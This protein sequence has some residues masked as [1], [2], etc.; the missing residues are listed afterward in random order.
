LSLLDLEALCRIQSGEL[1]NPKNW[2]PRPV[3][4]AH[5]V[6]A[7]VK[8]FNYTTDWVQTEILK[9]DDPKGRCKVMKHYVAICKELFALNNF[10]AVLAIVCAF[11]S[12]AIGRLHATLDLFHKRFLTKKEKAFLQE[13]ETLADSSG[14]W[15]K[16]RTTMEAAVPPGVP[17]IG[18]FLSDLLWIDEG[19]PETLPNGLINFAKKRLIGVIIQRLRAFQQRR[20]AFE[21]VEPIR[22]WLDNAEV[23]DNDSLFDLSRKLEPPA[24]LNVATPLQPPPS[25]SP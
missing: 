21:V 10:H 14:N 13:A 16:M 23:R 18:I 25:Q 12:P 6:L 20:Y 24:V 11:K 7:M 9:H 1:L 15:R 17:H 5:N 2:S 19:N 8:R 3:V 4:P 22:Q